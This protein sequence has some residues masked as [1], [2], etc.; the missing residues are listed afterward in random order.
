MSLFDAVAHSFTTVSTGGFSTH[1]ASMGYFNS[2][3]LLWISNLFMVLGAINFGLHFRVFSHRDYTEYFRDEETR[4]F[5]IIILVLSLLVATYLFFENTYT[6]ALESISYSTFHIISFITSTG[7]G[8]TGFSEWPATIT[9]LLLFTGYLGGCAGSTAGGN[10]IIRNI[11][12][13]KIFYRSLKQMIHPHGTFA[14]KYQ[15]T[16]VQTEVRSAV[17][18]FMF[19]SAL[20]T[21][22]ITLL[23]MTTGLDFWSSLSAVAACVNVLGPGFG[24]LGSNFA[25]VSDLG[26]WL[27]S[28]AMILGRLEYFTVFA[29]FSPMFWKD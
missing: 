19:F 17:M 16:S 24:Q 8:A 18:A 11:L 29:I 15:G 5:L 3:T 1:D 2:H 7:Y 14:I 9:L 28:G 26:T 10:K 21:I 4:V 27:L 13:V 20:S 25:P 6:N 12:T 22:I 23:L